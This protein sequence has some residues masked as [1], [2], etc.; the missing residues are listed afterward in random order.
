MRWVMVL[1]ALSCNRSQP[2]PPG[3][4][5][6]KHLDAVIQM[7]SG[8]TYDAS[9][10]QAFSYQGTSIPSA[11]FVDQAA[12]DQT[13]FTVGMY[14]LVNEIAYGEGTN[15]TGYASALHNYAVGSKR[16]YLGKGAEATVGPCNVRY[17]GKVRVAD[18]RWSASRREETV[19]NVALLR[20]GKKRAAIIHLRGQRDAESLM[21]LAESVA[22]PLVP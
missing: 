3:A 2:V 10:D 15:D 6:V 11:T 18:C 17:L 14:P 9:K 7:P 20:C 5:E 19:Q 8:F 13:S 16:A 21:A 12:T 1:L 22:T 4:V